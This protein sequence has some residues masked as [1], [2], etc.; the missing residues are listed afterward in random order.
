MTVGMRT[1]KRL[2]TQKEIKD[3]QT[4]QRR[5]ITVRTSKEKWLRM[6]KL[7]MWRMDSIPF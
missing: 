4:L 2:G 6:E 5:I 7:R 3:G 1:A